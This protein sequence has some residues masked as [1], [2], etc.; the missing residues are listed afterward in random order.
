MDTYIS[1]SLSFIGWSNNRFNNLHLNSSL[2]TNN[3][4]MHSALAAEQS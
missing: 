3:D 4:H 1:F 2:E